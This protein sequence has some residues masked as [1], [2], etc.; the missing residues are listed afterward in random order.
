[1]SDAPRPPLW[2]LYVL[3]ALLVI[4]AG[5]LALQH[6]SKRPGEPPIVPNASKRPAPVRT[7]VEE[8]GWMRL[9]PGPTQGGIAGV[10]QA[11]LPAFY[12][13][14][15]RIKP[16]RRFLYA[17]EEIDR[18]AS[19]RTAPATLGLRFDRDHWSVQLEHESVGTLPEIPAYAD[20]EAADHELDETLPGPPQR[21]PERGRDSRTGEPCERPVARLGGAGAGRPRA[22]QS[23]RLEACAAPGARRRRGR[24]IGVARRPDVRR[25]PDFR[26]A[27]R[28]HARTGGPLEGVATGHAPE[29]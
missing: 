27:G 28:A 11:D 15:Y 18:L 6:Y 1:M 3:G 21:D 16:D 14:R 20:W 7:T 10:P 2:R 13:S 5:A 25:A 24:R 9:D 4:A 12:R 22:G 8:I 19:G 17:V 29:R 23:P 26:P